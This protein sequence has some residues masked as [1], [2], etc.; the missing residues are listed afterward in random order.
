MRLV[1]SSHVVRVFE[2]IVYTILEPLYSYAYL[3]TIDFSFLLAQHS[4]CLWSS[5]T[6]IHFKHYSLNIYDAIPISCGCG[7]A[8]ILANLILGVTL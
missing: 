4:L 3:D 5:N 2:V 8:V 7:T 1:T 6:G